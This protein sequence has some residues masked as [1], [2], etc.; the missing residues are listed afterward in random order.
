MISEISINACQRYEFHDFMIDLINS[1]VSQVRISIE[2]SFELTQKM[3]SHNSWTRIQQIELQSMTIYYMMKMLLT[4]CYIC[5]KD[6]QISDQFLVQFLTLHHYLMSD[7]RKLRINSIIETFEEWSR[8]IQKWKISQLSNE[9][10]TS[11]Y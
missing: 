6:N 5:I 7:E 11:M 10:K 9:R 3:W 8:Q 4:N 1:I 2:Q